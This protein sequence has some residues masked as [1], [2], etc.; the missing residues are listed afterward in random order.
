M[1]SFRSRWHALLG[2]VLLPLAGVPACAQSVWLIGESHDQ[3]AHQQAAADTVRHLAEGRRLQALVLEMADS[4]RSTAGLPRDIAES[5]VRRVLSWQEQAWPW[6]RY[7]PLVMA[8]VR[9]GVPVLGGNRPRAWLRGEMRDAQW[10]T[11]VPA[12]ARAHL[13]DAVRVGHCGLL[14]ESQVPAMV[15][16]QVARDRSLAEAV[17][18]AADK[19]RP[20]A[21][22]VLHAG[23]QH[24]SRVAGVPVHLQALAPELQLRSIGF[25]A[26]GQDLAEVDQAGF[27]ELQAVDVVPEPDRC[28]QLG[29]RGMP[30]A[31][32]P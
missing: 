16:M 7:G 18:Q 24:A 17:M 28:A 12:G 27:D 3:P 31:S 5:E 8:A 32:A 20:A 23:A 2:G 21:V 30:P 10:D 29:A 13:A 22:V 11:A 4:G 9:V 26:R 15:R 14:P 25:I 6:E 1:M 19:A